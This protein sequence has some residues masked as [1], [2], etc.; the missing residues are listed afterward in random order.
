M[1]VVDLENGR[2]MSILVGAL[3]QLAHIGRNLFTFELFVDR[4]VPFVFALR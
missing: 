1:N 2:Y 4:A 3:H